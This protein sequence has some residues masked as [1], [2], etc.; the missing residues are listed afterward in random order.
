MDNHQTRAD[1]VVH[2][3]RQPVRAMK[4]E[5][6]ARL[7]V[8]L[9]RRWAWRIG[10][11]LYLLARHDPNNKMVSNG[12][13]LV[14]QAAVRL[15]Q[16][17]AP[18]AVVFDIGANVG[19]WT[20]QWL[21]QVDQ[22]EGL[23]AQVHAFE[24]FPATYDTLIGKLRDEIEAGRVCCHQWAFSD[25]DGS[26]PM[27]GRPNSGTSAINHQGVGDGLE[28]VEVVTKR[29]ATYCQQEGIQEIHLLKCDTEGHDFAVICGAETLLADGAIW[30]LQF[31]YN[32]R[33]V[34]SRHY[35]KDVFDLIQ[36][37][38]YVVSKITCDG[39]EIY[40]AWHPELERF[41]EGNYVLIREDLIDAVP[42]RTVKVDSANTFA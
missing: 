9:N 26:V 1:E 25:A 34:F 33:W 41:F 29:L 3:P 2:F 20:R 24:P 37:K 32:H 14:Q 39:L 35:L 10:R 5:T 12:E 13:L 22:A 15:A 40:P 30:L 23:Q 11:K 4:M 16:T 8:G 36:G 27:Y 38:P 28:Q 17:H 19:H 42:A 31:E 18:A 7:L 21:Q 6:W